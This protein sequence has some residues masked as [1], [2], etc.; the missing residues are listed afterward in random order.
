ML[1]VLQLNFWAGH[2]KLCRLF[3]LKVEENETTSSS[4]WRIDHELNILGH[5]STSQ[6]LQ[7]F[8]IYL[9]IT[10]YLGYDTIRK[11]SL[12]LYDGHIP[13]LLVCWLVALLQPFQWLTR[14]ST[15][16]ILWGI[17]M[18][19]SN[20]QFLWNVPSNSSNFF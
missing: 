12:I 2:M 18:L 17:L 20:W 13:V 1:R 10:L 3:V 14:T 11:I 19:H 7:I 4:S 15:C 5:H 9:R 8:K 16:H 6:N